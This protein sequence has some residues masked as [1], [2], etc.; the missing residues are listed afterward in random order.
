MGGRNLTFRLLYGLGFTPWDGHALARSLTD[1]IEGGTLTPGKALDLGCGTGDNAIYLA[2]HGWH[3]TGVDYVAKPLA[4]ARR[5]ATGKTV[6]FVK[7][8]V[9]QL[10][11]EGVGDGFDL[12]IDSG[13]LHGMSAGDREKYVREVSAVTSA[14]ARLLIVA[15]VPGSSSGVR[16]IE[17]AEIERRFA[18]EW[19]I[20][21]SGDEPTLDRNG[22]NP[23]R[24]YLL[25]RAGGPPSLR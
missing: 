16:G 21:A 8:D 13:C 18:P 24:H 1:L 23:A 11:S 22:T 17:P 14:E 2:E 3:V 15:V 7:A 20:L 6:E 10:S 5:K 12:V 9:T 4:K 25:A 19:T